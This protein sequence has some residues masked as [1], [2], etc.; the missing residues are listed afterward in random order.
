[1]TRSKRLATSSS[2]I[3]GVCTLISMPISSITSCTNWS[4]L[5]PLTPTERA[6]TRPGK[7]WRARAAAMGERTEFIEQTNSTL[8]SSLV[9]SSILLA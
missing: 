2:R 9:A 1:M 5:P 8:G 3:W 6:M 7:A 4:A